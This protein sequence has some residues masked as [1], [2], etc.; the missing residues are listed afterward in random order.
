MGVHG[1]IVLE[2]DGGA[3]LARPGYLAQGVDEHLAP[4]A[5]GI[6]DPTGV[7]L[8]PR[9]GPR[10]LDTP[11]GVSLNNLVPLLPM[12]GCERAN[13][14]LPRGR[15]LAYGPLRLLMRGLLGNAHIEGL[16]RVEST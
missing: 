12:P 15:R 13:G 7:G 5:E 1:S 6:V 3:E 2:G 4:S 14:G 10:I 9:K 8:H 11:L 16:L